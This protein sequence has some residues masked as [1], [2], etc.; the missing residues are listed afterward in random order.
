MKSLIK[1]AE[2]LLAEDGQFDFIAL[3]TTGKQRPMDSEQ[4]V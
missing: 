3:F 4:T 2:C 1:I